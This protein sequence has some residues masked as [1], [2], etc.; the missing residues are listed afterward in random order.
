M[1]N[2]KIDEEYRA[3]AIFGIH[4]KRCK[5]RIPLW[6]GITMNKDFIS[7]PTYHGF[8]TPCGE[9]QVPLIALSYFETKWVAT[10]NDEEDS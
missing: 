4:G 2:Q 6:A 8:D 10:V 5:V 3:Y 7:F 9:M 1:T